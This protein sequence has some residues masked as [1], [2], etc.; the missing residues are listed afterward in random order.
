[1]LALLIRLGLRFEDPIEERRFV[2]QYV[3]G[4]LGW[5]QIAMLLGAATYAGYTL[6]DWVLYPEVVPIT[7][8]IRGGTA[9]FVLLPLIAL[10]SRRSMKP[11]AETI[12]LVYCVVPGCIL[13]SV[14]LVL[15]SG[16]TFAA[17]GMM[18]IILFVSTMLPLRIGSL[19]IFCALS[20]VAL[21]VAESFAPTLPMGLRFINHSLVGNA[22]ALSLYAV[23]AREYRARRQF[24]TSEA[25]QREK[26]RSEK[27]LRDLRA[28]QAH[29]VQAEKLASLG[30]LVAGVAHEVSTPL[31]LAL[32]TSTAMHGDLQTMT[33]ALNGTSVRRSDLT[34]GI[35]RLQ[36]GLTLTFDN[37]QRA[38][39]MVHSFKQVAVNQADEDRRA[40]ELKEWLSELMA[41][42]GPLLSHHGLAV[43]VQCPSGIRLNSYPGALA[44]VISNL[45]FN[46]AGHAYPDKRGGKFTIAVHQPRPETVRLVCSDEG[47]G[48]P[49]ELQAHI[50]DP[51]V[52]TGRE[53][54]NAGLGLH[55]AFNLVASSLSGR[56]QLETKPGPGTQIAIEIPVAA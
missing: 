31:G 42:L 45:A 56:L 46:T 9:V 38:S 35:S 29:L 16:F 32:T 50:F 4:S 14:Y 52:T 6:W 7:L 22:Y 13:P 39:E 19:A 44:Q 8:A 17:A 43:E 3:R 18:M 49:D 23:A 1:M 47:V 26:E 28:T 48:I 37:L 53:S 11:R 51:F 54:G 40:F 21:I 2:D 20:W 34:K 12:F 5:T 10:L 25:L 33:N 30:Q 24:R 27:S 36:Q 15:P 41:R 55:I